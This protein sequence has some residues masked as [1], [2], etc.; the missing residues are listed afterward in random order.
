MALQGS[1]SKDLASPSA[2]GSGCKVTCIKEVNVSLLL[3]TS[4]C[5]Y[6]YS[7]QTTC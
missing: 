6:G 7:R 4:V 1:S 2:D 3:T 5:L